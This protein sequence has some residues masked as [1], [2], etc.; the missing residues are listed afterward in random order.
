MSKTHD[1][2]QL[3][4]E[5]E[6]LK[7]K[8]QNI[9]NK[10]TKAHKRKLWLFKKTATLF[11]GISLKQSIKK[12]FIEFSD[13]GKVTKDTLADLSTNLIKRFTR[14]GL[15]TFIIA[16]IP[17]LILVIQTVLLY[18]QNAKIDI[19]NERIETQNFRV[20]QQTHLAEGARR[21]TQMFIMG[22]VLKDINDELK[23]KPKG[24]RTL[25][26]TL[27]GRIQALAAAM[28]PY[29]YL[30]G[31]SLIKESIS[32]ERGQLLISLLAAD[33]D[34]ISFLENVLKKCDFSKS[35]LR[36][37]NLRAK[38]LSYANLDN[39]NL[40]LAILDDVNLSETKLNFAD[41][42]FA[43]L[44]GSDLSYVE[45]DFANLYQAGLNFANLYESKLRYAELSYADLTY[46]TIINAMFIESNLQH[47]DLSASNLMNTSFR[48][49]NL[50]DATFK[51]ANL[52]RADFRGTVLTGADLRNITAL[53]SVKV[54]R[55]DWLTYI[56][57]SLKLRGAEQ[58][59][60]DYR[61]DSV[62]YKIDVSVS[63][64]MKPGRDINKK[65][66]LIRKR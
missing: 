7:T 35:D 31:D 15:F 51:D 39:A 22:E 47:A 26:K 28:K 49:S 27:H 21:S 66:M 8:L 62:N 48:N 41:L 13:T 30:E 61:V 17:I 58:V 60:K 2:E 52:T 44:T 5:N 45:L 12:A 9:E 20:E 34:S 11:I 4:L 55:Y 56:K 40:N 3:K 65:P 14:I 64:I 25:S 42:S 57:D 6:V 54:D 16:I 23:G 24:K 38:N 32:P 59:F 37:T 19:Q 10:K 53:D 33:I 50:K 1:I 18:N 29:R 63:G 43:S 46:S 36:K